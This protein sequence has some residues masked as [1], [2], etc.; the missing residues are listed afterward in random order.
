MATYTTNLNLEKPD[1]EDQYSVSVFNANADKI[2]TFAGQVPARALTAD[3]L[4]TGAKINGTNFKGDSD[5]TLSVAT[6]SVAGTVKPDNDSITVDENGVI[7]SHMNSLHLHALKG[8]LDEGE[9][10]T[11]SEGLADVKEYAHSTFDRSKFTVIGSPVITADGIASGFSSSGNINSSSFITCDA[12]IDFTKKWEV[13]VKA[14]VGNSPAMTLLFFN[15]GVNN[16]CF[17]TGTNDGNSANIR[18]K[19]VENSVE[20]PV[21]NVQINTDYIFKVGWNLTKYYIRAIKIDDGTSNEQSVNSTTPIYNGVGG[22]KAIG[23]RYINQNWQWS[24][25]FDL[26]QFSITVDGV[27]VFSGNKTGIDTIKPN[28]YTVVGT[29]TIS[30]DGVATGFSGS[31]Y[32]TTNAITSKDFKLQLPVNFGS[33]P[34]SST[35]YF[36]FVLDTNNAEFFTLRCN[37]GNIQL[38]Y[39]NT[40]N[41]NVYWTIADNTFISANTNYLIEIETN[42]SNISTKV[43]NIDTDTSVTNS[44]SNFNSANYSNIGLIQF[45]KGFTYGSIDLNGVEIDDVYGDLIYQPCLKIPYT[46]SKTGSKIVNSIYRTRVK[47]M[48]EQEGYAPYY[49]LSDSDFTLPMGEV[50][51]MMI[52]KSTP[53]IVETY[54]NGDS[55]YRVWSD[56]WCEQGGGA[57]ITDGYGPVT[58]MKNYRDVSYTVLTTYYHGSGVQPFETADIVAIDSMTNSSFRILGST[59]SDTPLSGAAMWTTKGY[60]R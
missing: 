47:S 16:A 29:P 38:T 44:A 60:I 59:N 57:L 30:T 39:K 22:I 6:T 36:F 2:D 45:G 25:S 19:A 46:L 48:Y 7:S 11:D 28:D 33:N 43:T 15:N 23:V 14:H 55:W 12:G 8:Y 26:K 13:S 17:V 18:F 20:T 3:K 5:I 53:Y 34:F 41:A 10:L 24:G 51:G 4:T 32:L 40:S 52:N 31:N 56:G 50:Y 49:T 54:I 21:L 42:G 1:G 58:L 9:L 27:E 35:I 37:S